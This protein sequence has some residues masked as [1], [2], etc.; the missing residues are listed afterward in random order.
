MLS[1]R[2]TNPPDFFNQHRH[3]NHSDTYSQLI[4]KTLIDGANY[5]HLVTE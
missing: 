2:T 1:Q 5:N 3:T 4:K